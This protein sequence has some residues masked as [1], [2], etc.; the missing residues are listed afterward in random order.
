MDWFERKLL[1][2]KKDEVRDPKTGE[3]V[4]LTD[5]LTRIKEAGQRCEADAWERAWNRALKKYKTDGQLDRDW[6]GKDGKKP[7][8]EDQGTQEDD[9]SYYPYE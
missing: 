7:C 3:L 9:V 5:Y 6:P 2:W 1:G 8:K 4:D